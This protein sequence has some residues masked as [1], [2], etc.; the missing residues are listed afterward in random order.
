MSSL[1][2]A[3]ANAAGASDASSTASGSA[4]NKATATTGSHG[5]PQ[6]LLS[7]VANAA[8]ASVDASNTVPGS[9][10]TKTTTA[11]GSHGHFQPV[12]SSAAN[13]A[14]ASDASNTASG[15]AQNK[16]TATVG[17]HGFPPS[18]FSGRRGYYGSRAHLHNLYIVSL[19]RSHEMDSNMNV[20]QQSKRPRLDTGNEENDEGYHPNEDYEHDPCKG[21]ETDPTAPHTVMMEV[22]TR[23][24]DKKDHLFGSFSSNNKEDVLSC[25]L[26]MFSQAP[27]I[28]IRITISKA[29]LKDVALVA[30]GPLA[31]PDHEFVYCR[32]SAPHIVVR[33]RSPQVWARFYLPER[34]FSYWL[35]WIIGC[36]D[37]RQHWE[38]GKLAGIY[39]ELARGAQPVWTGITSSEIE[40]L[41]RRFNRHDTTLSHGQRAIVMLRNAREIDI[42]RVVEDD[43]RANYTQLEEYFNKLWI[44]VAMCGE[45]R[46][47]DRSSIYP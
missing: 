21:K 41:E 15:S 36:P 26:D 37:A 24:N 9:E 11:V 25:K 1:S 39:V 35:M 14:N 40:E 7:S 34:W 10:Q 43:L 19:K 5:Y 17:S 16:A 47:V 32:I 27:S 30:D 42:Y 23:V 6:P 4:Q 13:A 31:Q 8:N 29:P 2:S 28:V 18:P 12:L 46:V 38:E 45:W 3:T 33:D 20:E 44:H 22:K